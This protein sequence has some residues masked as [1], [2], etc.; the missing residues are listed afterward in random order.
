VWREVEWKKDT[1]ALWDKDKKMEF[2]AGWK[3]VE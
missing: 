3:H 2:P 1:W